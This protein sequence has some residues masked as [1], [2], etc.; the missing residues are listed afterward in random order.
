MKQARR[1]MS[2]HQ[3]EKCC[4]MKRWRTENTQVYW[5][6]CIENSNRDRRDTVG[7]RIRD[8][9]NSA[10]K[11][12][13]KPGNNDAVLILKNQL[14]VHEVTILISLISMRYDCL[15]CYRSSWLPASAN[16][17]KCFTKLRKSSSVKTSRRRRRK[18][19]STVGGRRRDLQTTFTSRNIR[20]HYLILL[21]TT[22]NNHFLRSNIFHHQNSGW[23]NPCDADD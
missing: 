11:K 9:Y 2:N 5:L 18:K 16:T 7:E 14:F 23:W 20:I 13:H 19:S 8:L 4:G 12:V 6:A 10:S 15:N 17:S 21:S 3:T 1:H 22:F